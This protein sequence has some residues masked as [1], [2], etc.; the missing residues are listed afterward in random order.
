MTL[1]NKILCMIVKANGGIWSCSCENTM[2]NVDL[3]KWEPSGKI[4]AVSLSSLKRNL[5]VGG[6]IRARCH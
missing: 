1:E 6:V 2:I 3:Y 4:F 5:L